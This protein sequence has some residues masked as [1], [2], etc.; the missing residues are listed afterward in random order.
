MQ[1]R[2]IPDRGAE[3]HADDTDVLERGDERADAV[4]VADERLDPGRG[5]ERLPLGIAGR[6]PNRVAILLQ[7]VRER[8]AAAAAADDQAAHY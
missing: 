1:G 8:E 7:R 6:A 2:H 4:R 3:E 5:D